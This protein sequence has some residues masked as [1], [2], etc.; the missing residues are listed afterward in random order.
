MNRSFSKTLF[1]QTAALQGSYW[2]IFCLTYSF[3]SVFLLSQNFSNQ[4]I[5]WVIAG[6]N[7]LSVI[8]QP[9]LG[10]LLDRMRKISIKL[11]MSILS[12]L[13]LGL[14][15]GL[16]F[17][18]LNLIWMA[19]LYVGIVSLLI[20]MQPLVTSLTFE[21]I[22][23]GYNI[24]FGIT[25]AMG[26]IGFAVLSILLGYW[27]NRFSPE[28]IPALSAGFFAVYL[29]LILSFPGVKRQVSQPI[30]DEMESASQSPAKSFLLRYYR[31][32]PFLIGVTCLFI[33]HMTISTFLAQIINSVGGN[34][35]NLGISFM[36]VAVCEL[37][38]FLGFSFIAAKF[39]TRFLLKISS[40]FFVLR[41]IIFL[42]ASSIFLVNL[43]Q[44]FQG[45]SFAIF[46][47]ASVY[48]I[49]QTMREE[50]R[51]KGQTYITGFATLGGVVGS[52]AG[53]WLLDNASVFMMLVFASAA[54][55]AGCLLMFYSVPKKVPAL[56]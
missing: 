6:S 13:A 52:I 16:I 27:V 44:V 47:P 34:T 49:N 43:G 41:S 45:V 40:V 9:L 29:L 7:I 50:D 10:T 20:T 55:V 2:M 3:S 21:Y 28:I 26:S 25:R 8:L 39:D 51:V 33:F 30:V 32:I 12:I 37:P 35:T 22:N 18:H 23:A 11:V 42:F 54:A 19:V 5:G 1:L 17:L 31:F 53:G 24:N 14:L 56:S 36:I 4:Q 46:L 48:F 38:A 15:T